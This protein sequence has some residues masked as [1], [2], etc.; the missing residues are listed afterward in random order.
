MLPVAYFDLSLFLLLDILTAVCWWADAGLR[1][2]VQLRL[3]GISYR[4]V[5]QFHTYPY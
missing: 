4:Y 1:E 2:F 5:I 3:E